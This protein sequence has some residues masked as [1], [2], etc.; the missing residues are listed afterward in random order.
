MGKKQRFT[1]VSL[2]KKTKTKKNVYNATCFY[3]GSICCNEF[4]LFT[5]KKYLQ[6]LLS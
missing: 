3:K 5:V 6:D 1:K 2:S 4:N